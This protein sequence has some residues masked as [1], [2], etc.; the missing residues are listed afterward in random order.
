MLMD[1][2]ERMKADVR[3]SINDK[4]QEDFYHTQQVRKNEGL[5]ELLGTP[6]RDQPSQHTGGIDKRK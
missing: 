5:P 2:I 3:Y 1:K 4:Q 6:D